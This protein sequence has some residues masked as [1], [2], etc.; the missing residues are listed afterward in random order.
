MDSHSINNYVNIIGIKFRG[1][2]KSY[3]RVAN[4]LSIV[5]IRII[6]VLI[7]TLMNPNENVNRPHQLGPKFVKHFHKN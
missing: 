1:P 7:I 2:T 4:Q 5:S 3:P 6:V